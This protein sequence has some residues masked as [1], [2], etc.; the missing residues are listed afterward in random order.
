[1]SEE[2][3]PLV[4][5]LAARPAEISPQPDS[6]FELKD[7]R[8]LTIG[9]A[10]S[11]YRELITP[12]KR[13]AKT[14]QYRIGNICRTPIASIKLVD[15]TPYHIAAHRDM[16]M[17]SPH[18]NKAGE[19]IGPATVKHELMLLSHLFNVAGSEWGIENLDNP[20]SKVR[21]PVTPPGRTRRLRAYEE[22]KLM[23]ALRS[24][25]NPYLMP[26]VS[27]ALETGARQG[28]LLGLQWEHISFRKRVAHLPTTKNGDSRDI[29]L[30]RAAVE[31]LKG[32]DPK[33]EGR[34]FDYSPTGI[35]SSWKSLTSRLKIKDFHFHDLRHEA[36]SRFFEKGLD[37]IEVSTISGHKSMQML[38]RYTHLSAYKLVAKLDRL[39][40]RKAAPI[41]IKPLSMIRPYPAIM[42]YAYKFWTIEFPDFPEIRVSRRQQIV[43]I[44]DASAALLRHLVRLLNDGILP[45]VPS[46]EVSVERGRYSDATILSVLPV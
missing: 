41:S 10:L 5:D 44:G 40:K 4:T 24:H 38:K 2:S 16:R 28:E 29:P 39:D 7:P 17:I 19:T 37:A 27:L 32:M 9:E 35:K 42:I 8:A 14:E 33:E 23:R 36:I 3:E 46:E 30:T 45:P 20:V 22:K 1:M 18:P 26:L 6:L 31:I 43:A 21:K 25:P 15:C 34:I 11:R 12:S 13:S